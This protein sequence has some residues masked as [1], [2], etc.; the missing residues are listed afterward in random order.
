M[1]YQG[2]IAETIT[3]RGARGQ[4]IE[5]Y[6]ARPVGPGPFPGIV[7]IH[8]GP[9]LDEWN[10]EF[11]RKFAH[12]GYAT[13]APNL[14]HRFYGATPE[15]QGEAARAAGWPSDD[16]ALADIA[17]AAD[18]LRAQPSSNGKLGVIGCC[19]G[20]RYTFLAASR[21]PFDAAVDCWGG[22]VIA[23]G[24]DLTASRPV[25]PIDYAAGLSCPILGLFGNEDANPDQEQVNRTEEVLKQH[26]KTYEFHR[27]DGAGH[28]FMI[29]IRPS[30]RQEQTL[31]AWQHIRRFFGAHLQSAQPAAVA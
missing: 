23:G 10:R 11:A 21:L 6:Y 27:Y 26:G 17:G 29:H 14:Y 22:S 25:A 3:T 15:A 13:I 16:Q 31:D 4:V 8:Y 20:G 24:A 19:A 9:G 1:N 12:N 7:L 30:Y 28:G 5:S 18:F 2:Q